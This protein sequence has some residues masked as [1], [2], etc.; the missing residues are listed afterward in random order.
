MYFQIHTYFFIEWHNFSFLWI[1]LTIKISINY[2]E[3]FFAGSWERT[4]SFI[5][6]LLHQSR[7]VYCPKNCF[8]IVVFAIRFCSKLC[9]RFPLF[10]LKSNFSVNINITNVTIE[11]FILLKVS[12]LKEFFFQVFQDSDDFL[13]IYRFRYNMNFSKF[14]DTF[15]LICVKNCFSFWKMDSFYDSIQSCMSAENANK[16]N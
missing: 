2:G 15:L 11:L 4:F 13:R 10:L 5:T 8:C 7:K 12:F 1:C 6:F 9:F 14:V 16:T 3:C